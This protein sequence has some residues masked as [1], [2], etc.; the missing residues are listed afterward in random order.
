MTNFKTYSDLI[1][2]YPA[3]NY[4]DIDFNQLTG[5]WEYNKRESSTELILLLLAGLALI[6]IFLMIYSMC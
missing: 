1:N 5:M 3:A 4:C 6:F 2:Y